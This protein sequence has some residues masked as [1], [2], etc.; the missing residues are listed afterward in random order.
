M[1]ITKK[2]IRWC[3]LVTIV[4]MAI[5]LNRIVHEYVD[6]FNTQLLSE[7]IVFACANNLIDEFIFQN[8]NF[9]LGEFI[10]FIFITSIYIY[11]YVKGANQ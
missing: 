7:Y 6:E 1:E 3:L 11:K 9:S 5:G 8:I 4:I 2:Q 10:V